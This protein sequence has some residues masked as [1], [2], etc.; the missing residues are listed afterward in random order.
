M[1]ARI[2]GEVLECTLS[3]GNFAGSDGQSIDY[4]NWK[5][6]LFDRESADVTE[7][8]LPG[9]LAD[10]NGVPSVGDRVAFVVQVGVFNGR[11]DVKLSLI[12]I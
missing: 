1:R 7:V 12:H 10:E 6:R 11:M 9:D 8:K 4:R 2:E 3:S 5:L